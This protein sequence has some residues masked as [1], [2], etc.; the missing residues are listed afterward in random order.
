MAEKKFNP[1]KLDKLNNPKRLADLPPGYIWKK[2]NIE[3]PEI[4][5]DIG[6]GTGFFSI[7]FLEYTRNG[8]VYAC[9]TS[10]IMIQWMKDHVTP[11]HPGIIPVKM[12]ETTLPLKNNC[13]DLVFM[14][15][16]HH[17]LDAP[18]KILDESFRILKDKGTIFI[19]DWKK[20]KTPEGPP[21][22]LR[23]H[24][25]TVKSQME[26]AGFENLQIFDERPRHFLVTGKKIT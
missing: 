22:E 8:R 21:L 10:D 3:N 11:G 19:A 24:P 18:D 15:H 4:L 14:I 12:E 9:D 13:A 16:L 5:V 20:E 7:P 1:A 26:N 2:L 25:E 6:A 17:E 23:Y